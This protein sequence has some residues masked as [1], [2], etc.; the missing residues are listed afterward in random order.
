MQDIL[1][2]DVNWLQRWQIG[3]KR[4]NKAQ[5]YWLIRIGPNL[6]RGNRGRDNRLVGV[7]TAYAISA[8]HYWCEFESRSG[9]GVQHNVIQ[10]VSD[11]RQFDGFRRLLRFLPLIKLTARYNWN[12]VEGGVNPIKQT[13]TQ[14]NQIS[15]LIEMTRTCKYF[16]LSTSSKKVSNNSTDQL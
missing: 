8:Y 1:P 14:T 3:L 9:R 5:M 4:L 12:I 16:P 15:P 13:N 6:P 7:T 10:F 2:S 11:L